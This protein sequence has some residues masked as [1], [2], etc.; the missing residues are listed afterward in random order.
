MIDAILTAQPYPVR[1]MYVSGVNIAVTYPDTRRTLEALRSLDFVAVAA[2]EMT[3]TAAM[4]DIVLP[5]TTALEEEEVSFAPAG[6]AV[7]YT[8]NAVPPSGE[9][10][11]DLDIA[12]GLLDRLAAR[13]AVTKNLIP[14]RSQR[15][16]NEFI[17]GDSG[18]SLAELQ[19]TAACR[20][21]T[22]S[23]ISTSSRSRRRAARS[24]CCPR[25]CAPPGSTRCPTYT[26]PARERAGDGRA[27][28]A[29]R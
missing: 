22:G 27:R 12:V 14:W 13:G 3:P 5:K 1:A 15:E 7:L 10:R 23:A 24:S 11:C 2:H 21:R 28:R 29:I 16:F 25:P 9:A 6:P 4:A 20:C 17:L 19:R 8:R 26:P 18:I